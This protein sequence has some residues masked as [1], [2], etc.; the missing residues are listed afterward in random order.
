MI[1]YLDESGDLGFDFVNK[2]PSQ[3]FVITLL[4]CESHEC[5][6]LIGK[7]VKRTLRNK[8]NRKGKSKRIKP[9]LKGA[10][11][12]RTVK[13]YFARQLPTEGWKIYAVVFETE[14]LR[15]EK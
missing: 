13:R 11:T 8:L 7:A 15:E 4:V 2:S 9:E 5:S 14:Y 6:K 1:I 3:K 10:D 12:S